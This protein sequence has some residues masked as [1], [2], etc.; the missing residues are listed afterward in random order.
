MIRN[1]R[2]NRRSFDSWLRF[3][4]KR[5]LRRGD[6]RG[7]DRPLFHLCLRLSRLDVV[8]LNKRRRPGHRNNWLHD[9]SSRQIL[10][11]DNLRRDGWR[12]YL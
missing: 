10:R 11:G 1:S 2:L 5:G 12:R 7:F 9:L 3:R 8:S 6:Y 4:R